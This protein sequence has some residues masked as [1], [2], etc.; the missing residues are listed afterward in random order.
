MA[1]RDARIPVPGRRVASRIIKGRALLLDPRVDELQRLNDVGS[2]LWSLIQE[3]RH[4]IGDLRAA[5]I[6]AF[7]VDEDTATR[8]LEEFLTEL[9][10]RGLIAWLQG[11]APGSSP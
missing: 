2:F 8:D 11:D 10:Q 5:I 9:E 7:E 4:P 3:R 1:D 6:D